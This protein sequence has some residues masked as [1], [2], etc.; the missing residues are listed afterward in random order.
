MP[1]KQATTE[2]KVLPQKKRGTAAAKTKATQPATP[3]PA[4]QRKVKAA[5][6][7]PRVRKA[8]SPAAE[9]TIRLFLA[10]PGRRG[11]ASPDGFESCL[12]ERAKPGTLP[13]L[14]AMRRVSADP[15]LKG[16]LCWGMLPQ[17]FTGRT[18]LGAAEL[19][20]FIYSHPGYDLYYL[21]AHPEQEAV[22]HSPWQQAEIEYPGFLGLM[23]EFFAA[24]GLPDQPL[25]AITHSALFATGNLI[26]A[27]PAFWEKYLAFCERVLAQAREKLGPAARKALFGEAAAPD[28]QRK[29]D[30]LFARLTGIFLMMKEP[31]WRACKLPLPGRE[32]V[33]NPHLRLLREMKDLALTR[34]SRWMVFCWANYRTLYFA[35]AMGKQWATR[36]FKVLNPERLN[37]VVP[38][39][40]IDYAYPRTEQAAPR[41]AAKPESR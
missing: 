41:A 24:V 8:V 2:A 38:T 32:A 31:G 23:H 39:G 12:L 30:L 25:D 28:T 37:L 11:K 27:S 6:S 13:Y 7:V 9:P 5:P 3:A 20:Q 40:T 4:R 18:G 16:C 19:R 34:R 33:L 26:V 14:D 10:R 1:R 22:F 29:L 21:D 36:N 15:A 17:D 35:Q